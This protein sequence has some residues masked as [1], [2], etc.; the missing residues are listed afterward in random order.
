MLARTPWARVNTRPERCQRL[1]IAAG[2]RRH[3]QAE[4]R[5]SRRASCNPLGG[6]MLR[7][8][9]GS[10]ARSQGVR[11][12]LL[13][14]SWISIAGGLSGATCAGAASADWLAQ[15][16]LPARSDSVASTQAPRPTP[17]PPTLRSTVAKPKA[18]S[19]HL[20]GGL[21]EPIEVNAPSPTLGVRLGRRLGAHLQGGLLVDWTFERKNLDQPINGLPGLQ[22]RLILARADG[23]LVPVMVFLE[24]SLT[25]KRLLVPYAG[26]ASG[27]EWLFLR[28]NDYVTGESA[29]ATYANFAWQSWGG[30][31]MRLDQGLRVDFELF[32]NGGSLE[33]NAPDSSGLREAVLVNGVGARVG[34]DVLY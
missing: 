30:M 14:A 15:S 24:V 27:Y 16:V 4:L 9:R 10:S 13:L 23:Q 31:G 33:R 25:E 21:F 22:P 2:E 19:I 11:F 17:P 34:L 8:V 32:Y 26:I 20:Y 12:Q 28:A 6:F 1:A 7:R 18:N 3:F 5:C 29:S